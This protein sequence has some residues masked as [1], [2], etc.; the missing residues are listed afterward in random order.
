MPEAALGR[1]RS[2]LA[3]H[4]ERLARESTPGPGGVVLREIPFLGQVGLR[5]DPANPEFLA[6]ARGALG[7]DL[8]GA[9]N[10]VS[11]AGSLSCLRLGPDEWLVVGE[12]G[13]EV[14]LVAR[15]EARTRGLPAA[16]V[17]L[18]A[19]RTTI[20]LSGA[21]S[22]AVLAKA[23]S[24]DL[25]PR[26]FHPGQCRESN[27]ARAQGIVW[28]VADGPPSGAA[29]RLLVRSSFAIYLALWLLDAMAEF[30]SPLLRT[31]RSGAPAS[32]RVK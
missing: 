10:T 12:P 31:T 5:G 32:S 2:P 15:L 18:S 1:R 24:L 28:L 4:H 6:A 23:T 20:E 29:W 22:R 11:T 25:H 26:A 8:P 16:V 21:K 19:A 7:L 17:D 30:G 9:P 3:D 13:A 27:L 14:G